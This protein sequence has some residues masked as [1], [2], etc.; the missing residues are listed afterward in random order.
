M[1][2]FGLTAYFMPLGYQIPKN[3]INPTQITKNMKLIM[4]IE[5][6]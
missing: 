1:V 2:A 3:A 6:F 5:I 4:K